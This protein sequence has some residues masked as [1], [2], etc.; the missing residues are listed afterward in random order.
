METRLYHVDFSRDI[1]LLQ[2]PWEQK[3]GCLEWGSDLH[4]AI[5]KKEKIKLIRTVAI[6]TSTPYVYRSRPLSKHLAG[7]QHGLLFD[8]MLEV[9]APYLDANSALEEILLVLQPTPEHTG[10]MGFASL[11][12]EFQWISDSKSYGPQFHPHLLKCLIEDTKSDLERLRTE[13]KLVQKHWNVR[14]KILGKEIGVRV[15]HKF[16]MTECNKRNELIEGDAPLSVRYSI[17]R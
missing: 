5:S 16:Y 13:E 6:R 17:S 15:V 4:W 10:K 2:R 11:E 12:Q 14:M 1:F 3:T 8:N 7:H 9:P